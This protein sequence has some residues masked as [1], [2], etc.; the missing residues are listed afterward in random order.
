[1]TN[2]VST[3]TEKIQKSKRILV[4]ENDSELRNVIKIMLEKRGFTAITCYNGE[5][6]ERISEERPDL[7][8]LGVG[9]V[10]KEKIQLAKILKNDLKMERTPILAVASIDCDKDREVIDAGFFDGCLE[11]PFGVRDIVEKINRLLG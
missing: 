9:H 7:I 5:T 2:K 1:M 11:Q 6:L 3:D 10:E 4:I 8:L